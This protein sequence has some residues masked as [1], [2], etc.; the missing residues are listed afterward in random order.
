MPPAIMPESF[1]T[2]QGFVSGAAPKLAWTLEAALRLP[3]GGFN[4]SAADRFTG[5]SCRSVIHPLFMCLE[6]IKLFD[7]RL[8]TGSFG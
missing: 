4:G 7:H 6:V 2:Q 5:M 8:R 3:A 1:Q